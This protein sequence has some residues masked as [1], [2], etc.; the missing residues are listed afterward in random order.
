MCDICCGEMKKPI[1]CKLCNFTA[2]YKCF[3]K[4]MLE[5]TLNPK[6][7]KCDKPWS[8][9]YLVDSFGQYF[10]THTYKK[11][12]EDV[13]FDVEKAMLP[14]T[15]PLAA[16]TL[17]IKK[18]QK[19]ISEREQSI[20]SLQ[21]SINRLD[22]GVL[23]SEFEEYLETRKNYRMQI[24]DHNEEK[25]MIQLRRDRI[26]SR[27]VHRNRNN[28]AKRT[29]LVVKCPGADCR[30][31]AMMKSNGLSCDLCDTVLCKEC[32]EP[33]DKGTSVPSDKHTCDPNTL[34]TVKLLRK[35]S[36]N[37]P[38]CKSVIYKIDGCDQMF[39]TQCHTA[40]SWRTGEVSTGRIHN[41]HYYEYLRRNGN[42]VREL[43][44]IPCGGL[45]RATRDIVNNRSYSKVHRIVAHFEYDEIFRLRQDCNRNEGNQDL[46]VSY[47]NKEICINTFKSEIYRREKALEKKREIIAVLTTFVVVCSDI[48]RNILGDENA[49]K[50]EKSTMEQFDNIRAFTNES[51]T[52]ISR[53]YKCVVP[54]IGYNWEYGRTKV[55]K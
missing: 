55:H 49:F 51:L 19:Q 10:V 16:Q 5:C 35:D 44:D 18:L 38:S 8:R 14:D 41:P 29:E 2:C 45:P 50:D 37:C 46:R 20:A 52:E 27:M 24:H 12:R 9:K 11:K 17:E 42:D 48:F 28:S 43:G 23:D 7:M 53:V 39:C 32:H 47:L 31:F 33:L 25:Y 36:K 40:F 54:V 6:C 13:L 4:Y 3:S 21:E 26:Y 15:Q 30:G 1:S 22:V 34:E